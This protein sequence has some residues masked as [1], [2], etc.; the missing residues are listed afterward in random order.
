MEK[1]SEEEIPTGSGF[2]GRLLQRERGR[3]GGTNE[4]ADSFEG[5]FRDSGGEARSAVAASTL[6]AP[7]ILSLDKI[8]ERPAYDASR[9]SPLGRLGHAIYRGQ[10]GVGILS[11]ED[12]FNMIGADESGRSLL[13]LRHDHPRKYIAVVV[14]ADQLIFLPDL[15]RAG[16]KGG[17]MAAEAVKRNV[18]DDVGAPVDEID[19]RIELFANSAGL[20]GFLNGTKTV[21]L[22][23]FYDFLLGF[24][25]SSPLYRFVDTGRALQSADNKVR[26]VFVDYVLDNDCEQVYIG[27]LGDYGYRA[28]LDSLRRLKLLHRVSLLGIPDYTRVSRFYRDYAQRKV[29]WAGDVFILNQQVREKAGI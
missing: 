18:A 23:V 13:M 20:R 29:S 8:N 14:D 16:A 19:V 7:A 11:D 22:E 12:D 10:A 4:P 5:I 6:S 1:E 26:A 25:N 2:L 21:S 3:R 15:L 24:I 17:R 27:G 9:E 28:E